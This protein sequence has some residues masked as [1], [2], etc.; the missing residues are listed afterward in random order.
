MLHAPAQTRVTAASD[1]PNLSEHDCRSLAASVIHA[2][3]I[4]HHHAAAKHAAATILNKVRCMLIFGCMLG[5]ANSDSIS[6]KTK[7]IRPHRIS[8]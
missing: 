6:I 1:Q 8:V 3:S 4:S 2:R 5:S 7:T